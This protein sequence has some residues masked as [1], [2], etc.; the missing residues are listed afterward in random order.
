MSDARIGNCRKRR[1]NQRSHVHVK[2][3]LNYDAT[4]LQ[5]EIAKYL[6]ITFKRIAKRT[7]SG[8]E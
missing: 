5:N 1:R 7:F 6:R 3:K 4:Y 8:D 2:N